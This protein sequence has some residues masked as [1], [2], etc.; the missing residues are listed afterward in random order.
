MT[1]PITISKKY[2]KAQ[3]D[4]II[5]ISTFFITM[6]L[7]CFISILL[8]GASGYGAY[9]LITFK[10]NWLTIFGSIGLVIMGLLIVYVNCK[11]VL[12]FFIKYDEIGLQITANDEPELFQLIEE[13]VNEVGTKF[14]KKVFLIP[15]INASVYYSNH[16]QSLF[17][18]TSKNL[19]IG[20]G[21]LHT[22][23]VNE[24]K[25]ILAHE[26][27]HFSQKS[28]TIGS[29]VAN[30]NRSIYHVLYNQDAV[31]S[32]IA[33]IANWNAYVALVCKGA[34]FYTQG[35]SFILKKIYHQL[36][37]QNL[38]L[39]REMEFNADEVAVSVVGYETYERPLYRLDFYEE[40]LNQAK[41]VYSNHIEDLIYTKNIY[42]N[43]NQVVNQRLKDN[44]FNTYKGLA[45]LRLNENSIHQLRIEYEDLWSS[46]PEVKERL[47]NVKR[48][49]IESKEDLTEKATTILHHLTH[50]EEYLTEE[51]FIHS[52]IIRKNEIT[53]EEFLRLY[54]IDEKDYSYAKE[55]LDFFNQSS[56]DFKDILNDHVSKYSNLTF[57]DVFNE[58]HLEPIF[59]QNRVYKE[60]NLLHYLKSQKEYKQVKFKEQIYT[61]KKEADQLLEILEAE[62]KSYQNE[63]DKVNEQVATFFK[64]NLNNYQLEEVQKIV[65]LEEQL[66][67]N[68]L[69]TEEFRESIN[70]LFVQTHDAVIKENLKDLHRRNDELKAR[71]K[72]LISTN[73]LIT[74]YTQEN[75]D[76]LNS[77][78][79]LDQL[80][81]VE[82]YNDNE[83]N[84]LFHA[85]EMLEGISYAL[86]FNAKNQFLRHFIPNYQ[87]EFA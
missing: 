1:T 40:C 10:I 32:I 48:L 70:W 75:I 42:R 15:E 7:S 71:L 43:F 76:R 8:L 54:F 64:S 35:L 87:E 25:G 18:P 30:I 11:F 29:Y 57:Q 44:N 56:F 19:N 74:F 17:L 77:F 47:E 45:D 72:E 82:Q 41:N 51:M 83:L 52:T 59:K 6:L 86:L 60:L 62:A 22:M 66:N 14:P 37:I 61:L 16:T 49:G 84:D 67:A 50:Y 13:T 3:K 63:V 33:D 65:M 39:S 23:T 68:A 5:W 24:L 2:K 21:L 36:E 58:Q 81:Y 46:H 9:K 73:K 12:S 53:D 28:M 79:N 85:L 78:I 55:Y 69:F 26:F 20:V 27:G 31:T 4:S 34:I 38:A 80:F